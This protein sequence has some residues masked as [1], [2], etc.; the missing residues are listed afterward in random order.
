MI[1]KIKQ[2]IAWYKI[3]AMQKKINVYQ[4]DIEDLKQVIKKLNK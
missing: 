2:A 4:N 3:T 1:N